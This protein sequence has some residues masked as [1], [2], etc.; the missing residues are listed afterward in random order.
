[1]WSNFLHENILNTVLRIS[2][3]PQSIRLGGHNTRPPLTN[4]QCAHTAAAKLCSTLCD[5]IDSSPPGSPSLGFSRQEHWSGLPLHLWMCTHA[6]ARTHTHP[7]P[8]G[9]K[10][11]LKD[12]SV[13][14]NLRIYFTKISL[15]THLLLQNKSFIS[16]FYFSWLWSTFSQTRTKE[17]WSPPSPSRLLNQNINRTGL[18]PAQGHLMLQIGVY[19]LFHNYNIMKYRLPS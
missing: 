7:T 3:G 2:Q 5:P 15:K 19:A 11:N 10:H 14:S 1:M 17:G 4:T 6:H 18:S 13:E 16:A 8:T 9:Q 12:H